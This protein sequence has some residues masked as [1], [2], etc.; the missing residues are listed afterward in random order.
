MPIKLEDVDPGLIDQ[1]IRRLMEHFDHRAPDRE[2]AITAH[3]EQSGELREWLQMTADVVH[4]VGLL[5]PGLFAACA[6]GLEIGY[7]LG[8]REA[9]RGT[10]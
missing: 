2:A 5:K 10:S 7:E 3:L 4:Q 8:L 6:I 1:A 9:K